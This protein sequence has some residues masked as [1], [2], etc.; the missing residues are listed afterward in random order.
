VADFTDAQREEWGAKLDAAR[1]AMVA[2]LADAV[3]SFKVFRYT[4]QAL[5][6]PMFD[7]TFTSD[8]YQHLLNLQACVQLGDDF[9]EQALAGQRTVG[10]DP[11]L[12]IAVIEALPSDTFLVGLDA[13]G[14]LSP[15]DA[16][17][18]QPVDATGQVGLA[19]A[20][21]IAAIAAVAIV[22][23]D[24]IEM[25]KAKTEADAARAKLEQQT[26]IDMEKNCQDAVANGK[27]T[28]EQCNTLVTTILGG[29]AQIKRAEAETTEAGNIVKPIAQAAT[30]GLYV[31]GGL[32]LLGVGLAVYQTVIGKKAA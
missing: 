12:G 32:A 20:I 6:T 1:V 26:S 22:A 4:R 9:V 24:Y 23:I 2:A 17:T 8:D 10:V 15:V 18:K 21:I 11:Q 31:I 3:T 28:A 13:N 25:Q 14:Y 30:T 29:Q 5:G 7:A 27:M 16:S 19:P